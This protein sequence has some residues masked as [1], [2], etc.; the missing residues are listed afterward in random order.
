[1]LKLQFHLFLPVPTNFMSILLLQHNV[2]LNY[3]C[4]I[5]DFICQALDFCSRPRRSQAITKDGR[6]T[7]RQGLRHKSSRDSVRTFAFSIDLMLMLTICQKYSPSIFLSFA[8]LFFPSRI[9][10]NSHSP[11]FCLCLAFA[12]FS[13]HLNV[14][15]SYACLILLT[16]LIQVYRL[17]SR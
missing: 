16:V 17:P 5:P 1:M 15:K 6:G 8:S 14:C 2:F 11:S 7:M 13:V 12:L 9:L 4:L 10:P 3:N